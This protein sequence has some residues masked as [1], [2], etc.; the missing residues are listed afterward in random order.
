[1]TNII[2]Y[3]IFFLA[4]L[5]F[6][7]A[8][9]PKIK[10]LPIIFPVLLAIGALL[11]DGIKGAILLKLLIAIVITVVGIAIGWLLDQRAQARE[12]QYA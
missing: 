2:G 5:G 6:G 12:E 9:P 1:M 7:Y 11:K 8:A 3:V 10:W 4:G